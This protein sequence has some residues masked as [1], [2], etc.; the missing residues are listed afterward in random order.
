MCYVTASWYRGLTN[1]VKREI[2]LYRQ[3]QMTQL[4]E[5]QTYV[6]PSGRYVVLCSRKVPQEM[7]N[8]FYFCECFTHLGHG[9]VNLLKALDT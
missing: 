9:S 7:M 5:F 8:L 1:W 6:C 3:P 4:N 2:Y